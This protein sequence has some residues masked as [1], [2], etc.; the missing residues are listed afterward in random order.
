GKL[1]AA[2][3]RGMHSQGVA[4]TPKHL[5]VNSHELRRM[6]SDSIVDERKLRELYLTVFEI[7]VRE[8]NQ[9]VII[10]AY[11]KINGVYAH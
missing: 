10:S 11:N 2:M 1:A 7:A 8:G 4:A 3:I 6:A 5:A 9:K